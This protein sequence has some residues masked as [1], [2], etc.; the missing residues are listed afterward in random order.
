LKETLLWGGWLFVIGGWIG[1]PFLLGGDPPLFFCLFPFLMRP[2][3]IFLGILLMIGG[4][5]G[6]LWCYAA[7]GDAWRMGIRKREKTV[8][9]RNGPYRFVRHPIY[10][11]QILMLLGALLLLP[12]P[13][14]SLLF[15]IHLLCVYVK[16]FDEETYLLTVHGSEYRDYLSRAGRFLPKIGKV[17]AP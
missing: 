15:G 16:A 5:A 8:L 14:S 9:V 3:G 6:T 12:T 17:V 2:V 1:Q 13:F 7:L 4:Y 10:L 11:F